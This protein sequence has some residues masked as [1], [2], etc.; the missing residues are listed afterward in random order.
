[1]ENTKTDHG[2]IPLG[3]Q[4]QS[5]LPSLAEKARRMLRDWRIG[6][7]T[8]TRTMETCEGC[9]F[10]ITWY[11]SGPQ[12]SCGHPAHGHEAPIDFYALK[13]FCPVLNPRS[14]NQLET[15]RKKIQEKLIKAQEGLEFVEAEFRG[16]C[17]TTYP[18]MHDPEG[19]LRSIRNDR[20][21]EISRYT[22]GLNLLEILLS[23]R[24]LSDDET[25]RA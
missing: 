24:S 18:H 7:T 19:T 8:I 25:V 11:C 17:R 21:R 5:N 6:P 9:R 2:H 20:K 15:A 10:Y 22:A 13:T 1:M 12:F 3:E 4:V 23:D 16:D 14:L